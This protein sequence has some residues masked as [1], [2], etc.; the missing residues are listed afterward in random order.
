MSN[1]VEQILIMED[2]ISGGDA[3]IL[4]PKQPGGNGAPNYMRA[5]AIIRRIKT[6]GGFQWAFH[7]LQP[8]AAGYPVSGSGIYGDINEVVKA[9]ERQFGTRSNEREWIHVDYCDP[10]Y[11]PNLIPG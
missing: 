11:P 9:A 2:G 3:I 1:L 8:S 7:T 6:H 5:D 10:D 4:Q